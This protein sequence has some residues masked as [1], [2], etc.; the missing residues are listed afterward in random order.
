MKSKLPS[1]F[2]MMLIDKEIEL[3]S[4]C[5]ITTLT[6]L[7]ELYRI[8]IEYYEEIKDSKFWDFQDRLQKILVKAPVL[9]LM[10]EENKRYKATHSVPAARTRAQTHASVPLSHHKVTYERNKRVLNSKLEA[11]IPLQLNNSN[12]NLVKVIHYQHEHTKNIAD[13]VLTNLKSQELSL[14]EKLKQRKLKMLSI[15]TDIGYTT[16]NFKELSLSFQNSSSPLAANNAENSTSSSFFFEFDSEKSLNSSRYEK[17]EELESIIE[18]IMEENFSE[19]TERIT[20]IKVKYETQ[21]NEF[22]GQGGVF[23]DIISQ[24]KKKMIEEIN[25]TAQNLDYRRKELITKAKADYP[26]IF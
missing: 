18:K 7:V 2:A 15:S 14:Q 13:K 23:D 26:R 20:E 3:E 21:I 1:D 8:G 4:D 25:Q 5:T 22:V 11:E 12:Q 19:K 9:A 16:G 24:M 17:T 6:E 10:Q